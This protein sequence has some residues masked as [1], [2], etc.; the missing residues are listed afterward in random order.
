VSTNWEQFGPT[1]SPGPV[2]APARSGAVNETDVNPVVF[3]IDPVA[4]FVGVV[5]GCITA[6]AGARAAVNP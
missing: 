3:V 6:T 4:G 5:F 2:A 1:Q